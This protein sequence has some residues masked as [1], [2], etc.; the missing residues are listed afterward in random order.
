[1]WTPHNTD[2]QY[3]RHYQRDLESQ[4]AKQRLQTPTRI[5]A[6]KNKKETAGAATFFAKAGAFLAR[7]MTAKSRIA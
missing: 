7:L 5:F 6:A 4:I 3:M 1:M 2:L